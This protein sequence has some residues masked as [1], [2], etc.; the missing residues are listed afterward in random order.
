MSFPLAMGTNNVRV[1]EVIVRHDS[2]NL[3]VEYRT[4]PPYTLA[5]AHLCASKS[6]FNWTPPGQ[7]PYKQESFPVGVSQHTFAVPLKDIG[8][9]CGL[10]INL[11]A[12]ADVNG[13]DGKVV[14]GAYAGRFQGRIETP[15]NCIWDTD[16]SSIPPGAELI[17]PEEFAELA[18]QDGAI[19]LNRAILDAAQAATTERTAAARRLVDS[20]VATNP[21]LAHIQ[22]VERVEHPGLRR[23]PDG[24]YLL[25]LGEGRSSSKQVVLNGTD[26]AY[27]EMAA[28]LV[29]FPS[30]SN[31]ETMFHSL[32][33]ALPTDRREGLPSADKLDAV[34]DADL[35][36][37]NR[38][39]VRRVELYAPNEP[40]EVGRRSGRGTEVSSANDG[41][42][43]AFSTQVD[44]EEVEANINP[45]TGC[46][47]NPDG[48]YANY[49]WALK[50]F[51]TPTRDQGRRGTCVAFGTVGALE[52]RLWRRFG[53]STDYS[54]QEFFAVAKGTWPTIAD[55]FGD[56]LTLQA[57][58]E[59]IEREHVFDPETRWPYNPSW[60]R[61]NMDSFDDVC[62]GY[63]FPYCSE[64]VHQMKAVCTEVP[65]SGV[66][67]MYVMPPGTNGNGGGQGSGLTSRVDMW[68]NFEPENSLA[69]IRAQLNA[70]NPVVMSI[71]VEGYFKDAAEDATDNPDEAGIVEQE[72]GQGE[73]LLWEG[74]HT[75]LVVGYINNGQLPGWVPDGSG[76]GYLVIKNSWGCN[77]GDMGY[78]YVSYNWVIDQ[79]WSANAIV[80][81]STDLKR[82]EAQLTTNKSVLT[83]P[84]KVK[85]TATVN[86]AVR[87]L[88]IFEGLD[89]D[90]PILT[91]ALPG[92]S[93]AVKSV[94]VSFTSTEQNG[95]YLYWAQVTDQFGNQAVSNVTGVN[96]NLDGTPP[97]IQLTAEQ[98][99]VLAP[100]TV[101]LHALASD[102]A[103]IARVKFFRGFQLLGQDSTEPYTL[104]HPVTYADLGT[105][106]Y[107]ALAYDT[108]GNAKLSNVVDVT[109]TAA[110]RPIVSSFISSNTILPPGG[111]QATLTWD[112]GG[113][114]SVYIAPRIGVV[115]AQGSTIIQ[116]A[117]TTTFVL[118]ATNSDG[119][120][121]SSVVVPV[122]SVFPPLV[123]EFTAFPQVLGGPLGGGYDTTLKWNVVGAQVRVFLDQGIGEVN[124][125]GVLKIRLLETK[126]FTLTATN[127]G[128]TV[129]RTVTVYVSPPS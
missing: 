86:A 64:T 112:V 54:E 34:S 106:R 24:N 93:E 118:S 111:G 82:P 7:C 125:Q 9:G 52:T 45:G 6:T 21:N 2:L 48:L 66:Y 17:S 61:V 110:P 87:E 15:I 127:P 102:N 16:A 5:T 116:V 100:G 49:N 27:R 69:S 67:C 4:D 122:E 25:T 89:A 30:R 12:Q 65:G 113:V 36:R 98:P 59:A 126:S 129:R 28:S 32:I 18:R 51:T 56:G 79:A 29:N 35:I 3:Y 121:L 104:A 47:N 63:D 19:Q 75:V 38:E 14:G 26:W 20:L 109:V 31:Q 72:G 11:Q 58:D 22:P 57:I 94:D 85:V 70:G 53:I 107:V 37:H 103:G 8:A 128:G 117:E 80:G 62:A 123:L 76:G 10:L 46:D 42:P 1:G 108:S 97:Q 39:L 43:S 74:W 71:Q 119:T 41:A 33:G 90:T 55:A 84:G 95:V 60:D 115:P 120:T 44:A 50:P 13:S 114:K 73:Q 40:F 96:V 124:T 77:S 88:R 78:M 83:A 105:A 101:K 68:N 23:L 99:L 92:G 81:V 91:A